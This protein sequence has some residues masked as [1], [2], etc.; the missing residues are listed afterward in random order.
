MNQYIQSLKESWQ[1]FSLEEQMANIGAEVGRAAKWQGKDD[2]LFEGAANRSLELFELTL[3]DRRWRGYLWEIGRVREL[4]CEA[5]EKGKIY[6]TTLRD[7][8]KYF[9]P[10]MYLA[11]K[12][13]R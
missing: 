2:K 1:E 5:A 7:L 11:A 12:E 13:S 6:N 9:M 4:F 8:E 10:F 3:N